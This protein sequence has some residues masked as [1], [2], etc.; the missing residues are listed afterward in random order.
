MNK[1]EL[2]LLPKEDENIRRIIIRK[3]INDIFSSNSF[4]YKAKVIITTKEGDREVYLIHKNND[5]L[6]TINNESIPISEVLD[7]KKIG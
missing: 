6:L 3:K 4:I 5:S 7:I 1:D 2:T